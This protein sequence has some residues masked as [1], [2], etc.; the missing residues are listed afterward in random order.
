MTLPTEVDLRFRAAAGA[1]G[2]V[3]VA[4]DVADSPLGPLFLAAT[5]R[6]LCR[7]A[8]DAEP[9]AQEERLARDF[10][11]RV[12][13]SPGALDE[14]RRELDDYFE[15]RRQAFDLPIDLEAVGDFQRTVLHRLAL[16]PFGTVTTYGALAADAGRPRA[17]RA[18][19][20]AMNRN[21]LPIVLPCHR[22]VGADG[23]LVGYGG[24]LERKV[25]LLRL[26]GVEL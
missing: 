23:R 17:A 21:P 19:G 9:E 3:D 22:V 25:A 24:G 1:E 7:V 5:D 12:L 2:L 6:G 16:V 4:Y 10:G 26:E 18:V 13:R 11:R 20:A 8:Y 15:G 14:A